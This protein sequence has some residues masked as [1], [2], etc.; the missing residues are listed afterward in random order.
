MVNRDELAS[1]V[2]IDQTDPL[3]SLGEKLREQY[4]DGEAMALVAVM[5]TNLLEWVM[6]QEILD[7]ERGEGVPAEESVL[8]N[9]GEMLT[10]FRK[11]LGR[12]DGDVEEIVVQVIS[13]IADAWVDLD[14]VECIADDIVRLFV[15]FQGS[16]KQLRR[17]IVALATA[18]V[19]A[20]KVEVGES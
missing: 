5:T 17:V 2:E 6:T 1:R 10:T 7:R 18:I 15:D 3:R 8:E 19:M 13:R 11:T 12:V 4:D 14:E 9:L 20:C 16:A